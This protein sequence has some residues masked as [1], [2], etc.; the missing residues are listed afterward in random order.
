MTNIPP[1][2]I[3]RHGQ[4]EWNA[5]HRLQGRLDSNLTELGL[6]QALQQNVLLESQNLERFVAYCS[7]QG[8]AFHTASIALRTLVPAINTDVRLSEIRMGDWEGM[9]STDLPVAFVA[10]DSPQSTFSLYE[11]A[12]NGEG[13]RA[14]RARCQSFLNDLSQPAVIVTHGIT[15]RMLRLVALGMDTDKIGD[16]PGG[17]GV[18]YYLKGGHQRKLSIGA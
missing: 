3:L 14:L 8:R 13:F 1:L 16:L 17:Q 10:D 2:Y 4:T 15:S 5:S 9:C 7:P 12:P 6:S 18:V 11:K